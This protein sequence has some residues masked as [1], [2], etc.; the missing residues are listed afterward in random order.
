MASVQ[1]QSPDPE[2]ERRRAATERLRGLFADAAPG[3]GLVDELI[4][5]RSTE[6][7]AED[8]EG[9]ARRRKP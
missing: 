7:L 1:R 9:E 5:D 3:E 2:I 4:A 8:R 6:A